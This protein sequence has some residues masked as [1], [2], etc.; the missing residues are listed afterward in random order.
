MAYGAD[1]DPAT[2]HDWPEYEQDMREMAWRLGAG[3][4]L[5]TGFGAASMQNY[6]GPGSLCAVA[7]RADLWRAGTWVRRR[8]PSCDYGELDCKLR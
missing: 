1:F 2:L 3:A 8:A 4:G 7:T 6:H 5:T